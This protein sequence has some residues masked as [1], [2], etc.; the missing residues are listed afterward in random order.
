M[1]VPIAPT[2]SDAPVGQQKKG[3]ASSVA[4]IPF[5]RASKWH[6][7][8]S[9]IQAGITMAANAQVFNFPVTS[10]GYLSGLLI[11][12]QATGGTTTTAIPYEDAPWSVL[13]Q[14]QLSDVNGVPL[15]QLS[16]FNAYLAAKYGG[17]RLFSPDAIARG[18]SSDG[19]S[20]QAGLTAGGPPG[21]TVGYFQNVQTA[22]GNFKF[23]L[24]IWLEFGLDGLGCLP[25]MDASAR[26]N[27]QI[28]VAGGA[29][30]PSATVGPLY[31]SGTITTPP[32]LTIT[33]EALC[34][35]QPPSTDMFGNQNSV[36]PPSVGTVQYWTAQTSSGLANGANTI[37]LTRVGNLIRNHILVF[38]NTNGTRATAETTDL[39]A[40]FEFDWDV[41]QRYVANTMTY[42]FF[43]G[44][45]IFGFENPNGV[46]VLPN[47]LDPDKIAL[48][49]YGDEWLGTVGATKLTLRFTAGAANGSL[50][51]LTNDIVPASAQIYAAP[52]FMQ[53]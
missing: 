36:S 42:R 48:S 1:P 4:L 18:A 52:K 22:T 10:Y 30:V 13:S 27:L 44:Y 41:A 50:T 24:P 45:P 51:V 53:G 37:Q 47:T 6:I 11:T 40:L 7:E 14:I 8:Q 32:T 20:V 19:N 25:N 17:Y 26:Y 43:N 21:A 46:V 15:F 3:S 38:R 9:N 35:S 2:P 39:P 28:T 16:G 31:A 23:I 33:V 5:A 12:V 49:E 34:R 29:N